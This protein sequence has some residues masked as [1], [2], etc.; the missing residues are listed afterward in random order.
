M[1][2]H[3]ESFIRRE[4]LEGV[5]SGLIE[6]F[7]LAYESDTGMKLISKLYLS[8]LFIFLYFLFY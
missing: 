6:I 1:K 4:S 2:H 8:A 5:E 7:L 3:M